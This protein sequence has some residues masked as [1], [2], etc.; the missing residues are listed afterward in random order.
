MPDVAEPQSGPPAVDQTGNLTIW[1]IPG[2]TAGINLDA[3]KASDLAAAS[4]K[5]ITYS[6]TPTGWSL[7]LPQDKEEDNRLTAPQRRQALGRVNP[8]LADLQYVDSD[9]P[10]S[11]ATILT[12]GSWIFVERRKVP[13]ATLAAAAQKIRAIKVNLGVQAPGETQG[14]GK[15]TLTQTAVIE[16]VSEIHPLAA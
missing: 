13:N 10:T 4:A 14:T 16:Y 1:C 11:A 12:S 2:A 5:R 8:D 3:I 6:F 7:S 15:F 9:D